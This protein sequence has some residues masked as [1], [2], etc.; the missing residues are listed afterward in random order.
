MTATTPSPRKTVDTAR[1]TAAFQAALAGHSQEFGTFFLA[2]LYGFEITYPGDVCEVAFEVA[3]FMFNPQGSLHGG[4]LTTALD[5]SMGH[6]LNRRSGPG[7]TLELKVQ[8]LAPVR[9]GRVRCRGAVLRQGRSLAF[10]TSEAHD[11]EGRMVAFATATWKML[12][13]KQGKTG[14]SDGT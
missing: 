3:D 14:A 7:A 4:V 13:P 6:L 8:F 1:A 9:G 5:I 2:R 11:D 12:D 10:L